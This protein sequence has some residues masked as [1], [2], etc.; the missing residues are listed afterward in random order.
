[1]DKDFVQSARDLVRPILT[2]MFAL[3]YNIT[4]IVA[5]WKG[6]LSGKEAI[7]AVTIPLMMIMTYHFTKSAQKDSVK[8]S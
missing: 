7:A 8:T 6:S 4:V 5:C 3:S 1:M 2:I